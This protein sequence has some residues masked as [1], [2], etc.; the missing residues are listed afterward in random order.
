MIATWGGTMWIGRDSPNRNKATMVTSTKSDST[1]K[2]GRSMV[3]AWARGR[4]G[5]PRRPDLRQQERQQGHDGQDRQHATQAHHPQII[6]EG[7]PDRAADQ[8]GG[9]VTHQGEHAGGIADDG[10]DDHGPDEI[11]LERLADADDDRRHQDDGGRVR[12]H[13][14]HRCHQRDDEQQESLA[15]SA[16]GTEKRIPEPVEDPRLT[17]HPRHHHAAKEQ[18]ERTSGGMDDRHQIAAVKDA[19]HE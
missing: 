16:G 18:G 1:R 14:A 2:P 3:T 7:Q 8:E 9:G 5:H 12:Q 11:D 10:R 15:A 17:D 13:G 6:D 19:G 4:Q